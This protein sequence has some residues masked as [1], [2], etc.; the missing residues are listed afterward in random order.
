MNKDKD[1]VL[2]HFARF[3]ENNIVTTLQDY[4]TGFKYSCWCL[5]LWNK[6]Y[7]SL[8]HIDEAVKAGILTPFKDYPDLSK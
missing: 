4:V 6:N 8:K 1:G 7:G 2:K 5:E 3:E